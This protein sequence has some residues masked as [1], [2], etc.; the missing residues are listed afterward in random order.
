[1]IFFTEVVSNIASFFVQHLNDIKGALKDYVMPFVVLVFT[2]VAAIA[3]RNSTL[4][5]RESLA[6]TLRTNLRDEFTSRYTILLEQHR[7]QLKVVKEYL[8]DK[9]GRNLLNTLMTETDHYRAFSIL[10]GHRVISPYMRVLYHLLRHIYYNYYAENVD[11]NQKKQYAS[12]VRSLIGNDVLFLIAVN[13]SYI[14]ERGKENDYAKYH[15]LLKEF[16]FFEHALFF[17]ANEDISGLKEKALDDSLSKVITKLTHN[18]KETIKKEREAKFMLNANFEL[19]FII[20]CIFN[21]PLYEKSM[22][23]LN[24]FNDMLNVELD[25]AVR[26]YIDKNKEHSTISTA[27]IDYYER[28]YVT[29]SDVRLNSFASTTCITEEQYKTYPV[30]DD[31][32]LKRALDALKENIEDSV[33]ENYYLRRY[34]NFGHFSIKDPNDFMISCKSLL[35]WEMHLNKLKNGE[36]GQKFRQDNEDRWQLFRAAVLEQRL[37]RA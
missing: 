37:T 10:R 1:M 7:E 13:S 22:E 32:Y 16:D 28:A 34:N 19:P 20:S 15:F 3:T 5:A 18:Y 36:I 4:T 31:L 24:S 26:E 29:A 2:V 23:Y 30:V 35:E 21:N 25:L 12:L 11:I 6:H 33:L 14:I 8:D 17:N 9:D 27:L